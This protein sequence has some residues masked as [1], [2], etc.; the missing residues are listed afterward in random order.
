MCKPCHRKP[1]VKPNRERENENEAAFRTGSPRL[2]R[3]NVRAR[4]RL[5]PDAVPRLLRTPCDIPQGHHHSVWVSLHVDPV[6]P[7]R[8]GLPTGLRA[9]QRKPSFAGTQ[10]CGIRISTLVEFYDA[11]GRSQERND[12][13]PGL[14]RY[15]NGIH[16][17]AV[18]HGR[19]ADRTG[20]C[21]CTTEGKFE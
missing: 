20:L 4:I 1:G 19:A 5:A 21:A 8:L 9:A 14:S 2:P 7:L 6:I 11:R 16:G 10:L 12:I 3:A 15:R 18:D 17:R 13:G